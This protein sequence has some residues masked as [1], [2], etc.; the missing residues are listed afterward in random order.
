[1][2]TP[3][4]I[5]RLADAADEA[6]RTGSRRSFAPVTPPWESCLSDLRARIAATL[7]SHRPDHRL[8][9]TLHA[10]TNYSKPISA[11]KGQEPVHRRRKGI[12]ELSRPEVEQIADEKIKEIIKAALHGGDPKAVFKDPTKHP[13]LPTHDGRKIPIHRVRVIVDAKP[14]TIAQ[15]PR[16]CFV[17]S[18]TD[19]NHHTVI[20]AQA[21]TRGEKW[22]DHP[23]DRL[24]VQRRLAEKKPIIQKDWGLGYRAIMWL[25]KGDTI[26]MDDENGKPTIYLVR[27]ISKGDISIQPHNDARMKDEIKES[28]DR[29]KYR[30]RS[31]T[32]LCK[33]HAKKV[34]ITPL[35]EIVYVNDFKD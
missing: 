2:A 1:M 22:E 31:A 8:A 3:A 12:A 9:G 33:R 26:Q 30:I 11:G 20:V 25:C 23:V 17:A 4:M 19:S 28:G 10:D 29:T 15:G 32:I 18:S 16:Q 24:E 21:T 13:T 5:K 27:G 6:L 35:G 7:V 14:K 34:T